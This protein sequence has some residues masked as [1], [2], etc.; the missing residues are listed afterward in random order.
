MAVPA[1]QLSAEVKVELKTSVTASEK[2]KQVARYHRLVD[3]RRARGLTAAEKTELET[4]DHTFDAW[5]APATEAM[6]RQYASKLAEADRLLDEIKRTR[7]ELANASR[8]PKSRTAEG[9]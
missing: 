3:L 9:F 5:E 2:K 4:L 7:I 8:G 6:E 1:R